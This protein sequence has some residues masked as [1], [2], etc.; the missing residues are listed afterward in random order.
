MA[1]GSYRGQADAAQ[2]VAAHALAD[3]D[4][5]VRIAAADTLRWLRATNEVGALDRALRS[6]GDE[7][8]REH[9]RDAIRVLS[10]TGT[11]K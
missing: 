3:V 1:T 7:T 6:E 4:P 9:L 11:K 10:P 8:A 2:I 5:T